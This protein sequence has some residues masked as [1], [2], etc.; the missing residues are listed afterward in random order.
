MSFKTDY[1]TQ[2]SVYF[3]SIHPPFGNLKCLRRLVE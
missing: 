3:Y 2:S 1:N